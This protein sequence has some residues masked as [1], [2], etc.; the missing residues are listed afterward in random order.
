MGKPKKSQPDAKPVTAPSTDFM[1]IARDIATLVADKNTA[2]GD[3]FMKGGEF[4][5]LLWPKGVPVEAYDDLLAFIRLFD[6]MMRIATQAGA[7]GEDPHGDMHGYTLLNLRRKR[8]ENATRRTVEE[9]GARMLALRENP[10]PAPRS[11]KSKD[12]VTTLTI[13]GKP[14]KVTL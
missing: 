11:N 7:F 10:S 8:I 9:L 1:D 5:K 6:K 13:N 14:R 12:V 3:S 2:Y 4:L